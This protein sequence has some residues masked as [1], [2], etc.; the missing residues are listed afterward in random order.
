M[1]EA[2]LSDAAQLDEAMA[3]LER[4]DYRLARQRWAQLSEQTRREDERARQI[5]R[6][7]GFDPVGLWLGIGGGLL[8]LALTLY[9]YTRVI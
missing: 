2:E 5:E 7:T 4:G 1:A 8:L 9:A 6:Q 3:A